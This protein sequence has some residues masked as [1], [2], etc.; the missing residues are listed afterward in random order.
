M[1]PQ[2]GASRCGFEME[3]RARDANASELV[4]YR[5]PRG[6]EAGLA[7]SLRAGVGASSPRALRQALGGCARVVAAPLAI[8][9]KYLGAT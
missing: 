5:D 7:G 9:N 4:V 3:M 6:L 2:D 1:R 8:T